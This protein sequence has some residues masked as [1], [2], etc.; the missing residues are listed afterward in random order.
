[1]RTLFLAA[2]NTMRNRRRS[3]VTLGGICLG[4]AAA[5]FAQGA[6]AG[7][8]G[9]IGSVMVEGRL[10]GVQIHKKGHLQADQDA[11][12]FAVPLDEQ[13][14]AKVRAVPGVTA[15]TPR[16][17]FEAM[18][19]NGAQSTMAMVT[20]VDPQRDPHV[21]PRRYAS[22][23][24]AALA[25]G[26]GAE[27]V[28]GL[29]LADGLGVEV[30]A[31][32]QLLATAP[33]GRPNVLDLKVTGIAPA[34]TALEGKRMVFVP[35]GYAQELLQLPG[36]VSEYA[37]SVERIE[38][39]DQVAARVQAAVGPDWQVV[40]WLD[41]MPQ[42]RSIFGVFQGVLRVNI[43]VLMLLLLTGV[44]NTM[45]MSV[46][47]RIRE[48]GTMLALGVRREQILRMVLAEAAFLGALGAST[49]GL[50]GTTLVVWLGHGGV[51]M[52]APGSDVEVLLR[53]H[54]GAV[55]V[56]VTLLIVV[57]VTLVAAVGP[58]LRASRL[59]PVEALRAT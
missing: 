12:N 24:G 18:I 15:V 29:A 47:E 35:L 44:A 33:G 4:V 36:K 5:I 28:L 37:L 17:S 58:A 41:L 20:A 50:I 13:L 38:D 54:V 42:L 43:A 30:G 19:A 9:L 16:L 49:G 39:A 48:F 51:S 56:A 3:L 23:R 32:L 11:L 1:M 10:G 59:T 55:A 21:C 6:V 2:R 40:S 22:V 26:A 7:I 8:M 31:T 14:L 45:V 25:P 52:R 53:P 34:S 57:V 27:G 46:H